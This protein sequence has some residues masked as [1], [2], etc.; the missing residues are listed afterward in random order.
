VLHRYS[1]AYL[2]AYLP[3]QEPWQHRGGVIDT[4]GPLNRSALIFL[5]F[6]SCSSL[7][8]EV[9]PA[10]AGLN[11]RSVAIAPIRWKGAAVAGDRAEA[12]AA[13]LISSVIASGQAQLA[14]VG[15]EDLVVERPDDLGWPGGTAAAVLREAGVTPPGAVRLHATL[16]QQLN[17]SE[18]QVADSKGGS[19]LQRNQLSVW[20]VEMTLVHPESQTSL[21]MLRGSC[22]ID[23]FAAPGPTSE[24]DPA[25]AL[26]ELI[27]SMSRA[28]IEHALSFSN[29]GE[30]QPLGTVAL[31][32]RSLDGPLPADVDP[33]AHDAALFTRARFLAPM[34]T[35]A[36]AIGLTS[37]QPGLAVVSGLKGLGPGDLVIELDGRPASLARFARIPHRVTPIDAKVIGP[38]GRM[39]Q[40]V[41]P[42]P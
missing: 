29:G 10:P 26:T 3:T 14:V 39:R 35:E 24:F 11:V 22:T 28:A 27:E 41:L 15:P 36:Q 32:P 38:D 17:E 8:R 4:R 2:F 9:R 18:A 23:P 33:L 30:K 1:S 21:L 31:T 5:L 37:K 34:L 7:Q 42:A 19:R 20:K 40:Q 25:P 16:E 6:A 12:V 13:R